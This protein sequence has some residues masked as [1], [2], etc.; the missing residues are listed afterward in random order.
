M[1]LS[2]LPPSTPRLNKIIVA[3]IGTLNTLYPPCILKADE[4]SKSE[5][6]KI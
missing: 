6:K 1:T 4:V 3:S 5:R 2:S